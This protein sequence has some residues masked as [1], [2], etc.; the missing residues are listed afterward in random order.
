MEGTK[1][2]K[3]IKSINEDFKTSHNQSQNAAN[4]DSKPENLLN[5]TGKPVENVGS[6]RR[7]ACHKSLQAKKREI[8]EGWK[9]AAYLVHEISDVHIPIF[10]RMERELAAINNQ[11]AAK[12]RAQ[13]VAEQ[14]ASE[15]KRLPVRLNRCTEALQG[16]L[17]A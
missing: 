5:G 6:G 11:I 10:E 7:P 15:K 4:A 1:F 9:I 17:N 12:E 3:D 13:K 2:E 14:M 16:S 8:E